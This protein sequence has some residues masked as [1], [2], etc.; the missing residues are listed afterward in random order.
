MINS[1]LLTNPRDAI[2]QLDTERHNMEYLLE[3]TVATLHGFLDQN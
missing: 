2:A 3:P 1:F